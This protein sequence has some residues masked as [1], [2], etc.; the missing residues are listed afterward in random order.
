M[1]SVFLPH[2]HAH[3]INQITDN[4]SDFKTHFFKGMGRFICPFLLSILIISCEKIPASL[5]ESYLTP[6][7]LQAELDSPAI[8]HGPKENWL[9]VTAK[10]GNRLFV[11]NAETGE[12]ITTIGSYGSGPEEFDYPNSIWIEENLM[13]IVERDNHRLQ[14]FHLPDFQFLGFIGENELAKPYGITAVR[15]SDNQLDIFVTDDKEISDNSLIEIYKHRIYHWTLDIQEN[16]VTHILKNTF[17]STI[18]P[19][20][21]YEVESIFPDIKY[22][23]LMIADEEENVIK[24]YT[25]D[26]IFTGIVLGQGKFIG[27]PEGITLYQCNDTDGFWIFTD[28]TSHKN[29]F[30]IFDR[31][32]LEYIGAFTMNLTTNTDGI[33]LTQKPIGT[34]K[35]GIFCAVNNDRNVSVL[36]IEHLKDAMPHLFNCEH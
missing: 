22:N 12:A 36:D 28:Q 35:S 11:Y 21:L 4:I 9:I 3:P 10:H 33:W 25:I 6:I 14:L 20:I 26:G 24:V 8:Y 5:N 27:D 34:F 1:Q 31:Q 19:G 30:Y 2:P 18:D 29:Q 7:E 17:G 13:I 32:S 16:S 23:R 15:H